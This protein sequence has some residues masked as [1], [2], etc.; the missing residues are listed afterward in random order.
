MT[1]TDTPAPWVEYAVIGEA[2]T[3]RCVLEPPRPA[4]RS[5][6]PTTLRL[7]DVGRFEAVRERLLLALRTADTLSDLRAYVIALADDLEEIVDEESAPD[8][9]RECAPS[10]PRDPAD[11]WLAVTRGWL[12]P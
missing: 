12:E 9:A 2:P 8:T 3:L 5:F 4:R 10:T 6:T 7:E 1:D 11:D